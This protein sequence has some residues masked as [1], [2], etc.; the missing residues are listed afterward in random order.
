MVFGVCLGLLGTKAHGDFQK[1][2]NHFMF[3]KQAISREL[4]EHDKLSICLSINNGGPGWL[5]KRKCLSEKT[6]L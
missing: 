3:C 6:D 2:I 4:R 1:C 5:K